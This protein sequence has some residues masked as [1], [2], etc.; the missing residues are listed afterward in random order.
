MYTSSML[1]ENSLGFGIEGWR[2]EGEG[3]GGEGGGTSILLIL[4]GG[5]DAM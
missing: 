5:Y 1:E 4:R 3:W 2:T